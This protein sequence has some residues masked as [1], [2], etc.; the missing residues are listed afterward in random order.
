VHN[1]VDI[2]DKGDLYIRVLASFLG[3]DLDAIVVFFV[4]SPLA[5]VVAFNLA[6]EDD[7]RR[8]GSERFTRHLQFF[9][10][11]WLKTRAREYC[12]GAIAAN[13]QKQ[14][15]GKAGYENDSTK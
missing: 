15:D 8:S 14:S 2:L 13:G 11:D 6:V 1:L 10:R 4:N 7:R 5:T 3:Q 12:H 9:R